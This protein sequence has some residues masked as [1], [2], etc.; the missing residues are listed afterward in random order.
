MNLDFVAI[1]TLMSDVFY[2]VVQISM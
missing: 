2:N 1:Y